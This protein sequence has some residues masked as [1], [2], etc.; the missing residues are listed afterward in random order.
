MKQSFDSTFLRSGRLPRSMVC[1]SSDAEVVAQI[2]RDLRS[3]GFSSDDVL[4]L[5]PSDVAVRL[6]A[7]DDSIRA[8]HSRDTSVDPRIDARD[9]V[10]DG[11]A[12]AVSGIELLTPSIGVLRAKLEAGNYVICV[13][14]VD[15]VE[16]SSARLALD[17]PACVEIASHEGLDVHTADENVLV[18]R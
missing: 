8:P 7:I 6:D 15:S 11:L 1:T 12:L 2:V 16:V 10:L 18:S 5:S 4:V 3:S 17:D 13:R 9:P 14:V